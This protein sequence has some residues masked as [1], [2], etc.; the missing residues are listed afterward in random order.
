MGPVMKK[1]SKE[2]LD[3]EMLPDYGDL[4]KGKGIRG[5][6]ANRVKIRVN[7]ISLAPDVAKVFPDDATVNNALRLLI[8]F[9]K[10]AKSITQQ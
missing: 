2:D 3:D 1:Q 10:R 7:M 5:K 4:L 9:T 6:Y 8:S